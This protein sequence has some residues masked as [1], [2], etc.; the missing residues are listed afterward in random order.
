MSNAAQ[1]WFTDTPGRRVRGELILEIGQQPELALN[2]A[3]VDSPCEV[4]TETERGSA[5]ALSVLPER[6]V[7]SFL[8]ITI[9]GQLDNGERL[10]LLS[11][12]NHGGTGTFGVPQYRATTVVAGA[13]VSGTMQ[14]YTAIRFQLNASQVLAHLES[15]QSAPTGDEGTLRVE[16]DGAGTWLVYTSTQP[17]P[18]RQLRARAVL[19]VVVLTRLALDTTEIAARAVEVRIDGD[20]RWLPVVSTMLVETIADIEDDPLLPYEELTLDRLASWI[21]TNDTLDMLAW[22]VLN[23]S[24]SPLPER[25]MVSTS[26]VEGLHRRLP[27]E[28]TKFLGATK[29]AIKRV[30]EAAV[31]AA[32]TQAGT[33]DHLDP[34]LVSTL[35][36]NAVNFV[37]DVSF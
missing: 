12:R 22:P 27:F 13:W 33:E 30:R 19:G 24:L 1:F 4:T 34:E 37:G 6:L 15:G 3:I 29:A 31:A 21:A 35:M 17:V 9:H 32:V 18:L 8:P 25:V 2:G 20:S 23:R 26:L 36:T 16:T 10:T 28:H 7:E 5:V 14:P 11:A